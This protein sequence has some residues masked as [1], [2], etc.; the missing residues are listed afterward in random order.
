VGAYGFSRQLIYIFIGAETILTFL[1]FVCI[2]WVATLPFCI[3]ATV[4]AFL[5]FTVSILAGIGM[6]VNSAIVP[7]V[8]QIILSFIFLLVAGLNISHCMSIGKAKKP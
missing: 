7:G 2:F 6:L 8:L 4:F 1:V 5:S 3:I